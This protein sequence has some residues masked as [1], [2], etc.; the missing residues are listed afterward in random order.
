MIANNS[1]SAVNLNH[2]PAGD[3][4]PLK[5]PPE[6]EDVSRFTIFPFDPT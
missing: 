4:V 2:S 3:T 1:V 5:A 6:D